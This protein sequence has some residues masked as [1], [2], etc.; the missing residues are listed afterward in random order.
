MKDF[1]LLLHKKLV[2][3]S[4]GCLLLGKNKSILVDANLGHA[5]LA[6]RKSVCME[7]SLWDNQIL[8]LVSNRCSELWDLIMS[9]E[10]IQL[11]FSSSLLN[12]TAVFILIHKYTRLYRYFLT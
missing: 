8:F 11:N 9:A 5:K 6:T 3:G 2:N 1:W 4:K 7:M 10:K 12:I